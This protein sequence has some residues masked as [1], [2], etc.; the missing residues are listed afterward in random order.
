MNTIRIKAI[1]FA[2]IIIGSGCIDRNDATLKKTKYQQ[3]W[4]EFSATIYLESLKD[5]L[6]VL[7][8]TDS[9]IS[10]HLEGDTLYKSGGHEHMRN[11]YQKS[12]TLDGRISTPIACFDSLLDVAVEMRYDLIVLTGDIVN[13]PSESSVNYVLRKLEETGIPFIYTA[14]NHDWDYGIPGERLSLRKEWTEKVLLPLYLGKDW[15]ISSTV[16][17]GIN[18]IAFDN[19]V[20]YAQKEQVEFFRKQID[21]GLP[22]VVLCHIPLYEIPSDD[23]WSTFGHPGFDSMYWSSMTEEIKTY[24][25]PVINNPSSNELLEL[26]SDSGNVIAVLTGH[27]HG[28]K[29][30]ATSGYVQYTT[31]AAFQGGYRLFSF[32]PLH[33]IVTP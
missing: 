5:S 1:I 20:A 18:F 30:Q 3:S 26:L 25:E 10:Y 22:I 14:G 21:K 12:T 8:L 24:Y 27:H 29:V 6:K 31:H 19:S 2:L 23:Y 13:Y 11:A 28:N 9:H 16:V 7:Q 33:E 32:Y 4:D 15:L 17:S